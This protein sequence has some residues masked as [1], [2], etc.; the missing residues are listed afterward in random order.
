MRWLGIIGIAAISAAALA[1]ALPFG[2]R[3][4]TPPPPAGA[5]SPSADPRTGKDGAPRERREPT[6]IAAR[7]PLARNCLSLDEIADRRAISDR[8]ILLT[9]ADGARV[10]A[11]LKRACPQLLYHGRFRFEGQ[12]GQICAELDRIL[13]RA[14]MRCTIGGFYRASRD[15]P[16]P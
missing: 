8:E 7:E 5:P 2:E 12:L 4:G 1:L 14:G 16:T 3:P 15:A 6:P 11:R 9:L 10:V 13:T